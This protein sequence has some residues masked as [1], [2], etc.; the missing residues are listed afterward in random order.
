MEVTIISCNGL[1]SLGGCHNL[2]QDTTS[3]TKEE[4]AELEQKISFV[5]ENGV[6]VI[7]MNDGSEIVIKDNKATWYP[8]KCS[9]Q[10]DCKHGCNN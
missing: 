10:G 6:K 5:T 3:F 8:D 2:S 9:G 1:N 4:V 7:V